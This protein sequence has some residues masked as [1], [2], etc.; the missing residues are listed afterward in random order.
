MRKYGVIFAFGV[1]F[2]SA[3]CLNLWA[4][5]EEEPTGTSMAGTQEDYNELEK[6]LKQDKMDTL[7]M[8]VSDM[9]QENKFL[10]ERV[11]ML[12]RSVNDLKDKVNDLRDRAYRT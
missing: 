11:K 7:E 9:N 12:E 4:A 1:L 8:R 3:L 5:G 10:T 2:F 6:T